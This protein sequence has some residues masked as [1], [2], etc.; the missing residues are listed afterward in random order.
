MVQTTNLPLLDIMNGLV[1]KTIE[2]YLY[3]FVGHN[4]WIGVK[5]DSNGT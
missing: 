5:I 3:P 1:K 2:T 4:E